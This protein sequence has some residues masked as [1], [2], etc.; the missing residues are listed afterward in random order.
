MEAR[1]HK[2]HRLQGTPPVPGDKSL[3]HRALLISALAQGDTEIS[4]LS[5]GDDVANTLRCVRALGVDIRL[6]GQSAVV[7]GVGL[8]GLKAPAGPLD[9]GNSGSTMRM[10]MGVLAAQ[11]F[12]SVMVG[13][14]SLS[15]RPMGRVAAPLC[16]MGAR[17]ELAEGK[18]APVRVSGARGLAP[19]DFDLQVASGQVKSAILLAAL[20]ANGTTR[21]TG[22]IGSR[23]H[24][25]R[26]LRHLGVQVEVTPQAISLHGGQA[27]HAAAI[28]IPGDP[29]AAAFWLA[30]ALL[31]ADGRVSLSNVLL[32]PTRTGLLRVL[33]RMGAAIDERRLADDPEPSGD[34][35][36][37]A[38]PLVGV[39]V[40]ADEVPSMID[41]LPVLAVIATQAQGTTEVRGASEL[42]V[43]ETDRIDA[44]AVN[45]RRM[46]GVI[47]TFADGFRIQGPQKL[48]GANVDSFGDH[49]IAM[50][51]AMAGLAAEGETR[52][53]NAESVSISHPGFF[54]TL[55]ELVR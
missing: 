33:R 54:E 22:Q 12:P 6:N 24:T 50:A 14:A 3:S 19:I 13:D 53:R 55:E 30:A 48:T 49:R 17:I 4:G 1:I 9:C 42:R 41:E 23:D 40:G 2:A 37:R 8:Q 44:I 21:L 27:L 15:R 29:S 36:C 26:L 31:V 43:K 45:L 20:Y 52:I 51:F 7:H 11:A 47:D 32:N 25:E 34:L 5:A 46:G 35:Q 16:R 39:S 18:H 10:L 28:P 38:G